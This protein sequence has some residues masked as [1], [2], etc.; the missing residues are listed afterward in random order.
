M[1]VALA[2]T[3]LTAA[4][5]AFAVIAAVV[6]APVALVARAMRPAS[7]RRTGA[8]STS[9]WPQE[10]IEAKVVSVTDSGPVT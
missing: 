8:S 9:P 5:A 7:R 2:V 6:L 4:V 10:T 3:G 1:A